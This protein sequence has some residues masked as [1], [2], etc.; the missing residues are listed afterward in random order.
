[1]CNIGPAISCSAAF[2]VRWMEPEGS[3]CPAAVI[4]NARNSSTL[5]G[6]GPSTVQSLPPAAP[7][8]LYP[9]TTTSLG[10]PTSNRQT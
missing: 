10:S 7:A 2:L 1:M 9:L 5:L 6:C 4:A 8:F 3:F